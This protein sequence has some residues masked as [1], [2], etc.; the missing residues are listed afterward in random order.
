MHQILEEG[1]RLASLSIGQLWW[2]YLALGGTASPTGLAAYLS[3]KLRPDAQQYNLIAQ[4]L[5]DHLTDLGQDQPVPYS[6][7]R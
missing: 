6:S 4:A 7:S 2:S 5:N 3:G 1:R